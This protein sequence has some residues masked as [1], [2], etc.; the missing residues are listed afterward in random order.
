MSSLRI[1]AAVL[2]ATAIGCGSTTTSIPEPSLTGEVSCPSGTKLKQDGFAMAFETWCE[3]ADGTLHG[4]MVSRY[5]SGQL[6]EI[7]TYRDG[8]REGRWTYWAPDGT[9]AA[10]LEFKQ[11]KPHGTWMSW[12]AQGNKWQQQ[13]YRDGMRHGVWVE[14]WDGGSRRELKMYK[15]GEP[16]GRFQWWNQDGKLLRQEDYVA[17][18]LIKTVKYVGDVK[19]VERAR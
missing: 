2:F 3:K 6:K 4:P 11:G 18:K 12:S 13:G 16:F 9:L 8:K 19:V 5:D 7:G 14:W 15:N 17:G 10:K 1:A